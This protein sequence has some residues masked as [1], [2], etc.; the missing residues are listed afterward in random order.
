MRTWV[1]FDVGDEAFGPCAA[2]DQPTMKPMEATLAAA[3]SACPQTKPVTS[4]STLS[5]KRFSGQKREKDAHGHPDRSWNGLQ[6]IRGGPRLSSTGTFWIPG[7]EFQQSPL[8]TRERLEQ[9]VPD[10][11]MANWPIRDALAVALDNESCGNS[12]PVLRLHPSAFHQVH[13][14]LSV[15]LAFPLP[16]GAATKRRRSCRSGPS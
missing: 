2:L 14:S 10:W 8:S 4:S 9:A 13:S 16:I 15:C 6:P 11:L 1:W 3:I 12:N 5:A 7:L